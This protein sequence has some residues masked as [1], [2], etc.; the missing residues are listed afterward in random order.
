[1]LVTQEPIQ[2][3]CWAPVRLKRPKIAAQTS[4]ERQP[5][6]SSARG[7]QSEEEELDHLAS[8]RCGLAEGLQLFRLL[9]RGC[10]GWLFGGCKYANA[11]LRCTSGKL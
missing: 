5:S 8:A 4:G 10:A 6:P 9:R 11:R 2:L 7:C 1:M 3:S